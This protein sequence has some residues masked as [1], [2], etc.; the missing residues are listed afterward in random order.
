MR[1]CGFQIVGGLMNRYSV[2]ALVVIFVVGSGLVVGCGGGGTS[3]GSGFNPGVSGGKTLETLT[4]AEVQTIC[5]NEQTYFTN[6][7]GLKD[8]T[9]REVGIL[10][11][12]FQ[13]DDTS[14]D[15]QIQAL[16]TQGYMDCESPDGGADSTGGDDG[17][18]NDCADATAPTNCKATVDQ[19]TACLTE[20]L[21]TIE[22]TFPAC[23]TLTKAKLASS[24]ATDGG[25]TDAMSGPA[26]TAFETACPGFNMD[27]MAKALR[28]KR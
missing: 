10:A 26:C 18:T 9:C 15:A 4:P 19:Y 8:A 3:P 24:S 1:Y 16:C 27:S 17:G 28:A 25:T 6:S 20:S 13:A 12:A 22:S 7:P 21:S 23:N 2:S 5:K 14:T 11:A